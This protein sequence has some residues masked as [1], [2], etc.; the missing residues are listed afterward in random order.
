[1]GK[2][3]VLTLEMK[4]RVSKDTSIHWDSLTRCYVLCGTANAY[5]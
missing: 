3:K 4:C 1:M 5:A 2:N